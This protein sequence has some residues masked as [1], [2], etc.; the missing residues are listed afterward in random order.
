MSVNKYIVVSHH[1]T[2]HTRIIPHIHSHTQTRKHTHK[3]THTHTHTHYLDSFI[4]HFF[5]FAFFFSPS[6]FSILLLSS[7]F[8]P[9]KHTHTH[10]HTHI[11]ATEWQRRH[12]AGSRA[13][14][15]S[16]RSWLQWLCWSNLRR[17]RQEKKVKRKWPSSTVVKFFLKNKKKKKRKE[18]VHIT[19]HAHTWA[20]CDGSHARNTRKTSNSV[21][22]KHGRDLR[23]Q[24]TGGRG[25]G[26]NGIQKMLMNGIQKMLMTIRVRL[27]EEKL[28]DPY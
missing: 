7:N 25:R 23:R 19:S 18:K 13:T 15:P 6:T 21:S 27:R 24:Q 20:C 26:V 14:R 8:S 3:H 12:R 28:T 22:R 1:I 11:P 9:I 5:F 17:K 2:S 10:T 16:A 4:L